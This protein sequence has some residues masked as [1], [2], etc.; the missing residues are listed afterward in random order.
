[1]LASIERLVV[2][3]FL[4]AQQEHKLNENGI[5]PC[6]ILENNEFFDT[7]KASNNV[8]SLSFKPSS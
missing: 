7:K 8:A 1:M 6:S 3:Y 2:K 4:Y 5:I